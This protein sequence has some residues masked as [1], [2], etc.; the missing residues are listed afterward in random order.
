MHLTHLC[1]KIIYTQAKY[2]RIAWG[3]HKHTQNVQLL[4][5]VN[6]ILTCYSEVFK[7]VD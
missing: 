2:L 1:N 7:V 4:L 6:I 5:K 3:T